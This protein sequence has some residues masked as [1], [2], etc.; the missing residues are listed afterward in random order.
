MDMDFI[1]HSSY[2]EVPNDGYD[3]TRYVKDIQNES[4]EHNSEPVNMTPNVGS[5][6]DKF[7]IDMAE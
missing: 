2:S 1:L 6:A 5:N 4:D 3:I 7:Y